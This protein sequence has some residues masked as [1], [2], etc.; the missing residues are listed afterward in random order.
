MLKQGF[1]LI[2]AIIAHLK[3]DVQCIGM[4]EVFQWKQM[5]YENRGNSDIEGDF[6]FPTEDFKSKVR[7]T[8][9]PTTTSIQED[10]YIPYNNVPMGVNHFNGKLFITM[11]RRR[12]GIPS[13]LNYID[14]KTV[15]S[16]RSPKLRAY[17]DMATN[18][19]T[20]TENTNRIISVYR[21][22]IDACNRL[23]FIDT[24]MLELPNNRIQVQRPS[25]WIIDMKK[26][27]KIH[28]FEIPE[29]IVATGPGLA[30]IT[31]DVDS[32]YCNK[33]FG[34]IPD[35]NNNALY[36]YSLED[37]RIWSF[38]HNFFHFDPTQGDLSIGGQD[39]SWNDGIFSV[40]LS[41]KNLDG[42]KTAYFHPM[43]STNEFAVSTKVLQEESNAAR[44]S[45]GRDFELLGTRGPR[46]QSTMHEFD[47]KTGIIFYAEIMQNGV[48]CWN[49]MTTEFSAKNHGQ[50]VSDEDRMIYPSD[51]TIDKEGTIWLMTNSMPI[52][53][54]SQLDPN[55]V[56]FRVWNQ[57]TQLAAENTICEA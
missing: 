46:K 14:L 25:I 8:R 50:V 22:R 29:S 16:N 47:P 26:N 5:D 55:V 34:Y 53:I 32:S 41:N 44:S 28:R 27:R 18:E 17:P 45:H 56:N 30:S 57:K 31:V 19:F 11:P 42:Y 54:Y 51:L 37:D 21:T 7:G 2:F 49:T 40:T 24:G 9:A 36:V 38:S 10:S 1:L 3:P 4:N 39:F 43:A 35:L 52:F 13:T 48:G 20:G 33:A 15:G 12:L 23:W 6:I